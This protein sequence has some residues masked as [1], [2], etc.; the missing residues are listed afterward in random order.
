MTTKTKVWIIA[1]DH[2]F[3]AVPEECASAVLFWVRDG[4]WRTREYDSLEAARE[5]AETFRALGGVLED[6]A[7]PRAPEPAAEPEAQKGVAALID[8]IIGELQEAAAADL[9]NAFPRDAAEIEAIGPLTDGRYLASGE[10]GLDVYADGDDS[11]P[12][13]TIPRGLH[14]A[15]AR[16]LI[17]TW[18]AGYK[19]GLANGGEMARRDMRRMLGVA[20]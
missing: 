14:P 11:T 8:D 5:A 19:R 6:G 12:Y 20:Q 13:F 1:L 10:D 15:I 18:E 4:E 16:R 3:E 17:D 2:H 9:G 7:E